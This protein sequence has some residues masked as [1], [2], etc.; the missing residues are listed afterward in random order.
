MQPF[1]IPRPRWR[2]Q[3]K[4]MSR[5]QTRPGKTGQSPS[6][7]NR[8]LRVG[9]AIS[10]PPRRK[11]YIIDHHPI[12][13]CVLAGI[14]NAEPDLTVCGVS[15]GQGNLPRV[16]RA[17]KPDLV[18]IEI[19]A[20]R[21]HPLDAL[22][23]IRAADERVPTLVFSG[24]PC[25]T[26]AV[27]AMRAGASGYVCKNEGKATIL[28]A[29]RQILRGQPRLCREMTGR[30]VQQ[31]SLGFADARPLPVA[32]LTARELKV[33][34]LLGQGFTPGQ[35][36]QQTKLNLATIRACRQR[37]KSKL[38]LSSVHEL[39]CAA[40]RWVAIHASNAA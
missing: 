38:E 14:I 33:F 22:R 29:T 9:A 13:R 5:R 1:D 32:L 18:I 39:W 27:E 30:L 28:R 25:E 3:C 26:Y 2:T 21:G 6:P 15:D 8:R 12:S 35:I 17:L 34:M 10:T 16:I 4:P 20:S 37:L 19:A 40:S 7:A 11:I 31:F 24:A 36:V 23:A